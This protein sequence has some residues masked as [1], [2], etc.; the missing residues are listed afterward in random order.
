MAEQPTAAPSDQAKLV[1]YLKRVTSDLRRARS[2]VAEL[3]ASRDA[4]PIVIVGMS[5]RYPGAADADGL[6]RVAVDGRDTIGPFPDDRGWDLDALYDPDP[7]A[8]GK[9]YI[10]EAGFL[11]TAGEFDAA[12]FGISPRE[13]LS[14]DPQQRVL[15][16]TAWEAIEHAGIDA[17]TLRGSRTGVYAGLVEQSYLDLD[18]PPEFEGYQMTGKLSSMASGRISY[19]LGLEGPSVS[20]DTACSSGLVALHLAAQALRAGEC[21][22]ALAG[23]AY[24]A[25]HPGGYIDGARQRGLAADGRCKPFSAAADG[26]GWSEGG[27]V[28]VVERLS[29]A[30]RNGHRVLAVVRG[31]AVN[32]D[33][34]S[35][36][37]TAP[38]GPSQERAI[39]AALAD[40]GLRPSEVDAVEAHGTGTR[41]GDPIEAQALLATYGQGRPAGRPLLLGSLKSNI[42]HAQA[43]AG[44]AG[45][46]KM[47]QA[48]RHAHLPRTLHLDEPSPFVDWS[49]GDIALLAEARDWPETGAPR[50]GAVSAFGA[51][52]T[53][54]HVILEQAPPEADA[55]PVGRATPAVVGTAP[56][57]GAG[58]ALTDAGRPLSDVDSGR[59]VRP[60]PAAVPWVLS[61]RSPAALRAQA[62][63]LAEALSADADPYDV[64]HS[65]ATTRAALDHRA[66]VVGSDR[67]AL[68]A[69]LAAVAEGEDSASV[70]R[71]TAGEVGRTVF[72]FPGQGSQWA[73]MAVPLLDSAPE[74]AEQIAACAKALE[75]FVDFSLEDVLRGREGAPALDR[76]DV[77]QPVLFAVMVS[78]A[79]LWQ[80]RGVRPDAVV[81]HSQGEVAAAY[82]A[83]ALSLEDAARVVALR[84]RIACELQ[85]VGGMGAVALPRAEVTAR[86]AAWP[87]QLSVT[88]ENG[89]N[90]VLVGGDRDA[91]DEF[92]A[93][94]KAEGVRVK[95]FDTDFASH[96]PQVELVRD[97]LLAA[98]APIEPRTGTVPFF[99]TV[100][101][102]WVDTAGLDADYW[103]RNLRGT[104]EFA[105][106]V[107]A[108]ADAGYGVFVEV[109]PHPVLQVS[110]QELVGDEAVLTGTLRRDEGGPETFL[111]ALGLLHCRGV[112]IDWPAAFPGARRV[113]LPTYAFQRERFWH[114]A[115]SDTLDTAALGLTAAGHPLLGAVVHLAGTD[116]ALFTSRVSARTAPWATAD[117]EG[118]VVLPSA[119]LLEVVLRAGDEV[120]CPAVAELRVDA[121]IALPAK[122]G[123][124]LQVRVG[125]PDHDGSRPVSVHTRPEDGDQLWSAAATGTLVPRGVRPEPGDQPADDATQ[126]D[127]ELAEA[128]RPDGYAL[129]P[130]LLDSVVQAAAGPHA[131]V[132]TWREARVHA[133]G[134]VAVH[135]T[136]VRHGDGL[137]LR[138]VDR[139]GQPVVSA[140]LVVGPAATPPGRDHEALLRTEWTPI[141]LPAAVAGLGQE[142]LVVPLATEPGEDVPA[143]LHRLTGTVLTLAHRHLADDRADAPL[144][145]RTTGAVSVA[146]EPVTD[147]AAAA[148]W[149]QVR[150]AQSENPGR[151]VLLDAGTDD[152]VAAVV[153]SGE[154]QVAVRGDRVL[155]PRLRRVPRGPAHRF[156]P[157]GT[158]LVTGGTGTLG[159]LFARHLVTRHGVRHLLLAGRR[160]PS[161]PGVAELRAELAA[162][163]AEVT[164]AACDLTDRAAV[165]EL[166]ASVPP[167][168]PLRAVLHAAGVIDD[169]LIAGTDHGRLAGVLRPKA[170]AAWHLH[171][172]TRDHDLTAFV[173]FSSLAGVIGG[174]GQSS[175]AAANTF[176]DGLAEHRAAAGL[177]A[178][179]VA[180]GLWAATVAGG[181]LGAAD[182]D[183][184]ARAGYPPIASDTGPALL[185]LA[186]G[187]GLPA[188]TAAPLDT[189][190]LR[191][192]PRQVPPV[193]TAL[194]RV[195]S[196]P[197]ARNSAVTV[198][199]LAADLAGLDEAAR[200]D[201]L[202]ALLRGEVG[203]VLG[204]ADP[205]VIGGHE[206]FADLGFDSLTG[207]ELRNR[208]AELT[209]LRL[210]TTLVFD[211]PT[212]AALA[213]HLLG[214]LLGAPTAEEGSDLAAAL[215]ADIGLDP[216]IRPAAEVVPVA[217][218][219]AEVLLTG[220]TGFLGA[221]LL[222]DLL[223]T[224]RAH[225]HCLVRAAD[226]P[227]ARARL[228]A[229]LDWYGIGAEVDRSRITVLPGD[230]A[231][232]SL[233]LHPD[234]FDALAR[235]VD[236]VYHPAAEVNWVR[237]YAA[238]RG[239][240]VLAVKE[241]LR[242][243]ARHRTVPLHHVSTLG[244]F[245]DG[246]SDAGGRG[247]AVGDPTGPGTALPTGYTQSKWVAEQVV[248]LARERGLPVSVYRIDLIAGDRHTGACQTRDFVWLS[249]KGM[250][251][252]GAAPAEPAVDFRLMP[253]DYASAAILHISRTE[254]SRTFHVSGHTT[255]PLADMLAELRRRGHRLDPLDAEAF[256]ARILSDQTNALVPL[257]DAFDVMSAAPAAFYPPIDDKETTAALAGTDITCPPATPSHFVRHVDFFTD[258]GYFPRPKS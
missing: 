9:F 223:R 5:A 26:I 211:H 182:V 142:V 190:A 97:E 30:R 136:L 28:L 68:V 208:L 22:L 254:H 36:G 170:D 187:T 99:S 23:A 202:L 39:R 129:H 34:A 63:R 77:V 101:A 11:E 220:A 53:N 8:L 73:D 235:V 212:L 66:V 19:T 209:G 31:S 237:P 243:A 228:D 102:D 108:L 71:G 75:P 78:L 242:L 7:A 160:G 46:V 238:V 213:D 138:A 67:A 100:T 193:L 135:A 124:H 57:G 87:G 240:N 159:A 88:V 234:R 158:V 143:A 15:L 200:R 206:R 95:R 184:I 62:A 241:L 110:V 201:R 191:A 45:L 54:A 38:N 106:S 141:R 43:A 80:A 236:A 13:A 113:E 21:D 178:T 245:L 114:V 218:D 92:L 250:L 123:L 25:A 188:L 107:T 133:V 27:G 74:F 1:E 42:G 35:N 58:P 41:L 111:R 205:D 82:V 258:R 181:D 103:Y 155:T 69:G 153:A 252:A 229:T 47:V 172:L 168:R 59:A 186:V 198:D 2:R 84:S 192:Q 216:D 232:A 224:T 81:G 253:V 51:S 222:R 65:L 257:L 207:V 140:D 83:G 104:V 96:S 249:L 128:H 85:G 60:A 251:Q 52:G 17:G 131:H 219:P 91:L 115:G 214:A 149:G 20:I 144:V 194:V 32:S 55:V 29:D 3:E 64:A 150:S 231:A 112:R 24:I 86:L 125:P 180:W 118:T 50:R 94:C 203:G 226:E 16:E 117:A 56:A 248:D 49:S 256:R 217:A 156:D 171:E 199:S 98:F 151:F 215:A 176:L 89:P 116:E 148:V 162:L 70:V 132:T 139:A 204:H 167:E 255:F 37:L 230:L 225:V 185:D 18:S 173:L 246:A 233:G 174:A 152:P 166:V 12:F 239:A 177:P 179:S 61:G 6:W 227:T 247:I 126:V 146:G 40:A 175:Y 196:R 127:A 137:R 210:P 164:V 147:P 105:R 76:L 157:T 163:G 183:R 90:A 154:A 72:V 134:A 195:P 120:A 121:P 93:G 161:A 130:A 119:A 4:D 14:M 145:F 165:A 109:S 221:Y 10:R 79:A 169:G 197:T 122:G 44:I 48:I 33:G 244:V 189:A